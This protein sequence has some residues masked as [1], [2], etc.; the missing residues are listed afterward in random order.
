[1]GLGRSRRAGDR[2]FRRPERPHDRGDD[3][4]WKV[5]LD[6]QAANASPQSLT[7]SGTNTLTLADV[8]VGDVWVCSGQSN[9]GLYLGECDNAAA[10]TPRANDPLLRILKVQ[11]RTAIVPA[12]DVELWNHQTWRPITPAAAREFS[13][14]AYFFGREL[15]KHVGAP[16]G[17]ISTLQGGSQ[18]QLWTSL[19]AVQAQAEAE[20]E[21][22]TWLAKTPG[23]GGR[24]IPGN[25]RRYASARAA[26]E[27]EAGALPPGLLAS[28]TDRARTAGRR[29]L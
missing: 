13:A 4:R 2:D 3:G 12:L 5:Y 26:F 10:E 11:E 19:D 29:A 24:N 25:S 16:I 28:E 15:R 7:V 18:I 8:L 27:A 23:G 22:R 14:V 17:L 20:P 9:M 21:F 1:M 6:K